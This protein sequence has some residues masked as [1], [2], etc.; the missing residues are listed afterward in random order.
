MQGA[1]WGVE[2]LPGPR[3]AQERRVPAAPRS[4]QPSRRG[5]AYI[6]MGDRQKQ[7]RGVQIRERRGGE[8]RFAYRVRFQNARGE[9]KGRTFDCAEDALDFRARLR[10]LKRAGDLA[11]LEAGKETLEHLM[12]DY[13]RLHAETRLEPSTRRK[14]RCLWNAHIERRLGAMELR[15]ITPLV[16]SEFIAELQ[17][18]GVGVPTI[19]SCLGLLQGMFARAVEWDRARVNVVK[20]IAKP[21]V[22]RARAIK[23]LRPVDVEALR[24]QMLRNP[25]H[26]LRDATLVSVLAYAGLRPE[27][28]LALDHEHVRAWTI[29]V[30]QKWVDGEILIGQKT[31][32]PSTPLPAAAE[33][34]TC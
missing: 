9:R 10:L 16:L 34:I 2:P 30:E 21:R 22:R 5:W 13:W 14:Y 18:H 28:T 26:G 25:R 29:L 1:F 23:P 15:Q 6:D 31:N 8:A 24:Q 20:L 32:R 33:S 7:S 17:R 11:A 19:R 27:E 4:A 12:G 3:T